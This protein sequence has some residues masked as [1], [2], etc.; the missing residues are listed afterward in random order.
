MKNDDIIAYCG[1]YCGACEMYLATQSNTLPALSEK[2]GIPQKLI[3]CEGCKSDS[4]SIFCKNC[5]I[6]KCNRL[7]EIETCAD[8]NE[9]PCSVLNAFENDGHPHHKGVIDSLSLLSR[10]GHSTWLHKM[11][12]KYTCSECGLALSWYDDICPDCYTENF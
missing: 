5:A 3:A 1:L 10:N 6:K 9:F 4:L 11:K 8:C 2:L 7:K 12:K